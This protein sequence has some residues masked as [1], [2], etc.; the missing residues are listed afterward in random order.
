MTVDGNL[1][2]RSGDALREAVRTGVGLTQAS[3]WLF[4]SDVQ[5][6]TV[7]S[8]LDD[9]VTGDRPI[10]VMFPTTPHLPTKLRVFIDFLAEITK[11]MN[12]TSAST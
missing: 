10:S 4:H 1:K 6:G 3:S 8:V 5:A 11:S 2:V 7:M 9:Y 12:A